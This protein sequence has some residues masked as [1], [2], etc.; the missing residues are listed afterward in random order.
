VETSAP[1][2]PTTVRRRVGTVIETYRF[3]Y[4][5]GLVAHKIVPD[6]SEEIRRL[7][8][9]ARSKDDARGMSLE[10]F[11]AILNGLGPPQHPNW[12]P[13]FASSTKRLATET[14][15]ITA[16][17]LC[18]LLS[19][20]VG[21]LLWLEAQLDETDP[22]KL[23]VFNVSRTKGRNSREVVFPSR[24]VR[25]LVQYMLGERAAT[26]REA[27]H[28]H[29]VSPHRVTNKLFIN[30][31]RCNRRDMGQAMSQDVLSR[32]FAKVV[33]DLGYTYPVQKVVLGDDGQAVTIDGVKQYHWVNENLFVF[34]HVRHAFTEFH[35]D[36]L[37]KGGD[38]NPWKTLQ[39]LLGHKWIGTTQNVYGRRARM[40][41][42][43]ITD[44]IAAHLNEMDE[45]SG[46]ATP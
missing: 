25:M 40:R 41:E 24:L 6:D 17:R 33:A 29:G 34:H 19:I 9:D 8:P 30:G 43:D 15:L 11:R 5:H 20:T 1:Y 21:D 39:L 44:S 13:S 37:G 14:A 28:V 45:R 4:L 18:E 35:V 22:D 3:A 31:L 36:H 2:E 32:S 42:P 26:I 7:L 46:G 10:Q 16:M 23:I 27:I 12:R 38:H